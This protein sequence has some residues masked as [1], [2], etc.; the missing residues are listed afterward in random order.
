MK[1]LEDY[2]VR[3][4]NKVKRQARKKMF[5]NMIQTDKM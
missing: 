1:T 4:E 3:L 5:T 2:I